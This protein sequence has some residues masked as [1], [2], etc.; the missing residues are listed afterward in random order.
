MGMTRSEIQL[1]I[2]GRNEAQAAIDQVN[3]QVATTVK[4]ATEA[5]TA[6][7]EA[8]KAGDQAFKGAGASAEQAAA[9]F[10]TS[11]SLIDQI[12]LVTNKWAKDNTEAAQRANAVA[13]ALTAQ[14]GGANLTT[15]QMQALSV[16]VREGVAAYKAMG[17]EAPGYLKQLDAE[18]TE[19][20]NHQ[21]RL[22][23]E[24]K[25]PP[26]SGGWLTWFGQIAGGA[27]V[28][29]LLSSAFS[30]ALGLLKQ[31]PAELIELGARGS[32]VVDLKD[33]FASLNA[34][35]GNTS[36][37]VLSKLRTAFGGTI[38]DADLMKDANVALS[39]GARLTA[40]DFETLAKASRNMADE[41]GDKRGAKGQFEALLN[42]IAT[43]RDKGLVK[44]PLDFGRIEQAVR[45][46]AAALGVDI[47]KLS[48][49]EKQ[50]ALRNAV[51][52]QAT[53]K[54]QRDG[55]VTNDFGDNVL[56]ARAA[57]QNFTDDLGE[58]IARSPAV[59]AGMDAM[60]KAITGAVGSDQ[61]TRIQTLIGW[62]NKLAIGVT[63]GA[64]L[65]VKAFEYV[66]MA[67]DGVKTVFYGIV[68][69]VGAVISV[70]SG[71]VAGLADLA[72]H[73]P[74]VGDEF[75]GLADGARDF[76][77]TTLE[78]T[79]SF[80]GLTAE[81]A[82]GT[83][84]Y[85]AYYDTLHNV[86]KGLDDTATRMTLASLKTVDL[87]GATDKHTDKTKAQGDA[88]KV[89][90]EHAK[91]FEKSL[92][93]LEAQIRSAVANVTPWNK[94][95]EEF[96]A[97][98]D[99]AADEAERQG[100]T[101]KDTTLELAAAYNEQQGALKGVTL[102]TQLYSAAMQGVGKAAVEQ[103]QNIQDL[104]LATQQG[105]Q[106][107]ALAAKHGTDL[108][109]A[110]IEIARKKEIDSLGSRTAA[111]AEYYDKRKAQ[112][113]A[114][115]NHEVDVATGAYS[116]L[117]ERMRANGVA[118]REDTQR[119]AEDF[120]RDYQQMVASGKYST[121]EIQ[122]AWER[123]V[124][125]QATAMGGLKGAVL[126]VLMDLP[127][128]FSDTFSK[129]LTGQTSV[130]DGFKQIWHD[131]Q[132]DFA[133]VLA[134]MLKN[135]LEGFL[136]KML[137][138]VLGSRG[139]MGAALAGLLSGGAGG[140]AGVS[141]GAGGSL[142]DLAKNSLG[143]VAGAGA[144]SAGTTGGLVF[145]A[146]AAPGSAVIGI[147]GGA[148]GGGGAGGAAAG[149]TSAASILGGGLLAAQGLYSLFKAQTRSQNVIGGLETGAGIGTMILPGIGTAIGAGFGALAGLIKS[150]F[151]VSQKEKEGRGVVS[152]FQQSTF[153][154]LNDAQRKEAQGAV[155]SGG[156]T[157]PSAAGT[158][159]AVRD[160]YKSI[161]KTE[162]EAQA[163]VKAFWDA[164]K[165]GPEATTAA[166][167][168]LL[169][170]LDQQKKKQDA[171][172]DSTAAL[173]D[174]MDG[175]IK[176]MK[177]DE[178]Q[179][180]GDA[181]HKAL[182]EGFTG[183]LQE[184]A[185]QQLEFYNTLK[186]GDARVKTFFYGDT[187]TAFNKIAGAGGAAA[188]R[189]QA[190]YMKMADGVK[191]SLDGVNKSLDDLDKSEKPEKVM[192][193]IEKAQRAALEAQKQDLEESLKAATEAAAKAAQDAKDANTGIADDLKTQVAKFPEYWGQIGKDSWQRFSEQFDHDLPP[194]HQR[195]VPDYPDGMPD[196][197][198]TSGTGPPGAAKGVM[199]T[200]PGLV[201]FGEGGESELGG[202][203][204][205]FKDVFDSLGV[206]TK[207]TKSQ[208]TSPSGGGPVTF[209]N[210]FHIS[211]ISLQDVVERQVV[212][213]LTDMYRHDRRKVRTDHKAILGVT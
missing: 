180:L 81:A 104:I 94:L 123:M 95:V 199:A 173:T 70:T 33:H 167:Q 134:R 46:H 10:K 97:K 53:E 129:I 209:V 135:F 181:Y 153:T 17:T 143:M 121:E 125:A 144:F 137:A 142:L 1:L 76:G 67:G 108:Q 99:K 44:L 39:K 213:I 4:V 50:L 82:K 45:A 38:T 198:R 7:S 21:K 133:S 92:G 147:P 88:L 42:V 84:G 61:S 55:E 110:Q 148:A 85:G 140:G 174:Q 58:A 166:M 149:G 19:V 164:E 162:Q 16:T 191:Q 9:K 80:A 90:A 75:K 66:S 91:G 40:T 179:S 189:I 59:Q 212:P 87:S 170:A 69:A 194:I 24:L 116:T 30:S 159:I 165:Q 127:G 26:D 14:G 146:G 197:S 23:N 208:A 161:G 169:A 79:K 203:R 171:A 100:K 47:G 192:G 136:M 185:A 163:D 22:K 118:T 172:G 13:I 120:T 62:V 154:N 83:L 190:D 11:V 48:E 96:G 31:I 176:A 77:R 177:P 60:G 15:R 34:E 98:A 73:L 158:L 74:N 32:D 68:T 138:G 111:N 195:V 119:T 145:G 101:V 184:F 5:G 187:V 27:A 3:S 35:I 18:L 29:N 109:L 63:E 117:E 206:G 51:L 204:S 182:T 186:E 141:G 37:E 131:I 71:L 201:L 196:P 12:D 103:E 105:Q 43:G 113:D 57:I 200:G 183:S 122:A 139:P 56:A 20:E 6:L 132:G 156:W 64:S 210:H 106:D 124:E 126:T 193:S 52:D 41:V 8:G 25:N 78:S 157:D 115:Y 202:P 72:S 168:P 65:A 2:T 28:G 152:D 102:Q 207:G 150:F 128:Q 178:I 205:F 211:G 112:I 93:T 130:R 86:E 114:T 151:G 36:G 49:H 107:L 160:A 175:L 188:T 155:A 89:T 54:L